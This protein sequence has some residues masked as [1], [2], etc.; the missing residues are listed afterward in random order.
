VTLSRPQ[1]AALLEAHGLRP[2]RALG[3][4]F[5]VDPNT[6]RRIA[7]L[8]GVGP[9]DQVLEIGPGLGSLTL[10]LAETGATVRAVEVDAHL[11]PVVATVLEGSGAEVVLGDA[12]EVD[13]AALLDAGT[14]AATLVAN[15]PYNI[16]V[17]LVLR[18][19]E[20]FPQITRLLVMVQREVGER[21]VAAP[22]AEAY[23]SVSVAV[24][25]YAT[26][27]VVAK[28]PASVFL[29]RPKVESV[30]VELRRHPWPESCAGVA[31]A[32]LT[33][34]VRR[35]FGQRRKMLR[36]S[37]RGLLSEEQIAAAGVDPTVRAETCSLAD[38]AA[39]ARQLP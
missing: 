39:L 31:P 29:P 28:V 18:V 12:L 33:M 5:V 7:R 32:V 15:L 10:A 14:T 17:P 36:S 26:G 2:S 1:A 23:G 3:Q 21:L 22:G 9:G 19:L 30:L 13:F 24:A 25:A 6:V 8:A 38:F 20:H 11:V 4:N 35:A 27:S 34:V 37:L 16:S